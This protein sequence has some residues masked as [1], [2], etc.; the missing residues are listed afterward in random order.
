MG[1]E[2]VGHQEHGLQLPAGVPARYA[3]FVSTLNP[4]KNIVRL[5]EAFAAMKRD[6]PDL[7]HVLVL[8][9]LAGWDYED[10]MAAI[11]AHPDEVVYLGYVDDSVRAA[12]YRHADLFVLPSLAEGFG[13]GILEAF[14]AGVPVAAA[15]ATSL[16]EVAGDAAVFFDP[17]DI[18][19]MA[20]TMAS[21]LADEDLRSRL[22]AAGVDRLAS[23]SWERCARETLAV[24][25]GQELR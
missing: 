13:L 7:P 3:L 2:H 9:G 20:A 17:L 15:R 6:H 25:D 19:D 8:A 12:L 16:P 4:R 5:I 11:D 24:L 1:W 18:G 10:I 22:S 23:F 21:V 14:D